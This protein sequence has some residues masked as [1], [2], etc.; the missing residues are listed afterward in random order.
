MHCLYNPGYLDLLQV[1]HRPDVVSPTLLTYSESLAVM[2]DA[3]FEGAGMLL[4]PRVCARPPT[5][6]PNQALLP[7][8]WAAALDLAA[9]SCLSAATIHTFPCADSPAAARPT[10]RSSRS[11][12]KTPAR[13]RPR[14]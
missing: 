4:F 7:Y 12:S 2:A 3:R 8:S 10:L 9:A 1:V 13:P 6:S 5:P 11:S 14:L